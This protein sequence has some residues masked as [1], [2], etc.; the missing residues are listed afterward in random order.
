MASLCD[1]DLAVTLLVLQEAALY[2]VLLDDAIL[3]IAIEQ[4]RIAKNRK[5]PC[6]SCGYACKDHRELRPMSIK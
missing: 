1:A 3:D 5:L 2:S 6:E 4:T